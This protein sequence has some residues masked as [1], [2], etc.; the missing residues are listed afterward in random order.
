[1]QIQ[2]V[3]MTNGPT[4][5]LTVLVRADGYG[6]RKKT[7]QSVFQRSQIMAM[8]ECSAEY[9]GNWESAAPEDLW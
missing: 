7:F 9:P 1:M 4:G 2:E 6:W 5:A 3:R 8:I